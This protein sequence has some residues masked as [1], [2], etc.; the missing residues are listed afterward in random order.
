MIPNETGY[1]IKANDKS[2]LVNALTSLITNAETIKTMG[3][4][5]RQFIETKAMRPE[6]MY[7]AIFRV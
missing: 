4:K 3:K 1:V 7:S 2:A 6:D 5:A